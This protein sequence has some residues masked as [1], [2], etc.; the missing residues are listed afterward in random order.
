MS[1]MLSYAG[2]CLLQRALEF[3]QG[4][5]VLLIITN[6]IHCVCSSSLVA[7]IG[8]VTKQVLLKKTLELH[9]K[10]SDDVF[11]WLQMGLKCHYL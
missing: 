8:T 10:S 5:S 4:Q 6:D 7:A 9:T 11:F 3:E 2:E 1:H